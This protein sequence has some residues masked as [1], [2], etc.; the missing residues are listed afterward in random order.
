VLLG[1]NLEAPG[2]EEM[3]TVPPPTRQKPKAR[4]ETQKPQAK[5]EKMEED[6]SPEKQEVCLFCIF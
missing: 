1:I 3:D 4:S 6:I 5:E 2:D